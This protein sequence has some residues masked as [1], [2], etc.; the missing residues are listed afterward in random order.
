MARFI[1]NR[2][3]TIGKAPGTLTFIGHK[4]M[5][6]PRFR[7]ISYNET[8][9][10]EEEF[11]S[12]NELSKKLDNKLNQWINIDGIHDPEVISSISSHFKL[13]PLVQEDI[14]NTD[15]RPKLIEENDK[16]VVFLKLLD[17]KVA[18][19][20]LTSDQISLIMGK[21]ILISFQEN[22]GEFFEPIRERL[23]QNKG[24]LRG[25]GTD[26][27]LYRLIDAIVDNYLLIISTLGDMIEKNEALILSKNSK[28]F[29]HQIYHHKTEISFLRKVVWPAKEAIKL[30]KISD[31]ELIAETTRPYL[32][33]LEG[34][35]T[36]AMETVEIYYSMTSDQLM[37]YNTH[38]GNRS[39]EV[40]KVLTIYASIFIPLTFIVGVYGTNFE[41]VPE[42]HFKYG[43]FGMWGIMIVISVIML[44]YFRRRKWL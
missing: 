44:I 24:K 26:Y 40:M 11:P 39:N 18:N 23:R 13:S 8:R 15:Q 34:L 7:L 37:V 35:L 43:Y 29:I 6:H 10:T 19:K 17:F 14:V 22:T 33:D 21:N 20:N 36:H 28:T 1:K 9:Y 2:S 5:E 30:I 42:Y 38:L 12:F 31:A 25:S 4:K 32:D 41:F 3:N 27:L 16:M